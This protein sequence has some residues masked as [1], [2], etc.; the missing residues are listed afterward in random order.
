MFV[1]FC[2][3]WLQM[4][5]LCKS[6]LVAVPFWKSPLS[7][8]P[9]CKITS[10]NRQSPEA[11][12]LKLFSDG[13]RVIKVSLSEVWS[14][15]VSFKKVLFFERA[16][17]RYHG[18]QCSYWRCDCKDPGQYRKGN[19]NGSKVRYTLNIVRR[20]C[21]CSFT[22]KSV[23]DCLDCCT[24]GIRWKGVNCILQKNNQSQ[25]QFHIFNSIIT[26]CRTHTKMQE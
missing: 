7:Y 2:S 3:T 10:G 5:T 16:T 22:L 1:Y 24:T 9:H 15:C 25:F 8:L 13:R 11:W 18:K 12:W 17:L 26:K 20:H 4:H 6:F 21:K 19:E 23:N 14:W